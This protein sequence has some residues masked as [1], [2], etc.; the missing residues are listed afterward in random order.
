VFSPIK[1]AEAAEAAVAA[2]AAAEAA[3]AAEVAEVA[4]EVVE[5]AEHPLLGERLLAG[6]KPSN[7]AGFARRLFPG[8]L[9]RAGHMRPS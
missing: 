9:R 1:A 2:A 7:L 3:E 8:R 6:R 4:G 5:V